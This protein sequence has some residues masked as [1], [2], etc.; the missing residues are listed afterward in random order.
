MVE[1]RENVVVGVGKILLLPELPPPLVLAYFHPLM[2]FCSPVYTS[3]FHRSN[4]LLHGLLHDILSPS[5]SFLMTPLQVPQGQHTLR[6]LRAAM[7]KITL[8]YLT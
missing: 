4:C 1:S 7:S 2:P 5:S 3:Y 8:G 6:T